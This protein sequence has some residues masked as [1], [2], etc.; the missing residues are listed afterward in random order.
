MQV[1][2]ATWYA[3]TP[4]PDSF[5]HGAP[6]RAL[7][8]TLAGLGAPP[9]VTPVA[10]GAL[11]W[12]RHEVAVWPGAMPALDTVLPPAALRG[13]GLV[14]LHLTGRCGLAERQV[15]ADLC[16]RM[17]PDFLS[18]AV[19]DA[20]Q[21]DIAVGDLDQIDRAGALRIAADRLAAEA[22]DPALSAADRARAGRALAQLY[23]LA[24]GAEP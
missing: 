11:H 3:G 6:G 19:T 12:Q 16:A 13:T 14:Q 5:R 4:E 23:A 9:Q 15:L 8:V 10:T 2:P 21:P 17:G 7:A 18:F 24:V 1:G 20:L 22:G